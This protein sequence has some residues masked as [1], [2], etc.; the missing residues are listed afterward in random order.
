MKKIIVAIL[1]AMFL[2]GCGS[3]APEPAAVIEEPEV[4]SVSEEGE[5]MS[6]TQV[7]YCKV[8]AKDEEMIT[9]ESEGVTYKIAVKGNEWVQEGDKLLLEC[10]DD[11]L[12]EESEGTY[13]VTKGLLSKL[14]KNE[15]GN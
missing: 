2:V 14:E 9:L 10:R 12:E 3:A 7:Y 4:I 11:A 5:N 15:K 6:R 13:L 1:L 8:A